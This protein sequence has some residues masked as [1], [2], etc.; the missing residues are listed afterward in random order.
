MSASSRTFQ[1]PPGISTSG[2]I[3]PS[4]SE[5]FRTRAESP[6]GDSVGS[7]EAT[8]ADRIRATFAAIHG[9]TFEADTELTTGIDV[10]VIDGGV[11]FDT[12]TYILVTPWTING[13]AFPPDDDFPS[14]L[15]IDGRV[16]SV[17][18]IEQSELGPYRAVNLAPLG[19]HFPSGA[20][21]RKVAHAFAP[22]FRRA[23]EEARAL[24]AAF[25]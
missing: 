17:Y 18:S 5:P 23:V 3:G 7:V 20:H 4:A 19:S 6:P 22:V 21:A 16:R 11:A 13:L 9:P 25:S 2:T 12:P 1:K 14:G 8:L 15:Q 24:T 10:E